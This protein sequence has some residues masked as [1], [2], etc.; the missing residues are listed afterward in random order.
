[1]LFEA[2]RKD[3]YARGSLGDA[4]ITSTPA[5]AAM[6]LVLNGKPGS[7]MGDSIIADVPP[8][9][10]KALDFTVELLKESTHLSLLTALTKSATGA[11]AMLGW[12]TRFN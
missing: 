5:F 3:F 8:D 6:Q 9:Y 10:V 12:P 11:L 7:Q 4:D 2:L 1:M